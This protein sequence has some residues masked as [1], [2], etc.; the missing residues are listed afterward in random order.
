[1]RDTEDATLEEN[2]QTGLLVGGLGLGL[3]AI[4]SVTAGATANKAALKSVRLQEEARDSLIQKMKAKKK[5]ELEAEGK[6]PTEAELDAYDPIIELDWEE[7]VRAGRQSLDKL[8]TLD[9]KSDFN[10]EEF[11]A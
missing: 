6:T 9:P 4:G 8:D 2:I 3:G 7:S 1:M 11:T 5:A 10:T